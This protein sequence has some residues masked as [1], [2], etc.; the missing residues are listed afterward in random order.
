MNISSVVCISWYQNLHID[1]GVIY[2]RTVVVRYSLLAKTLEGNLPKLS[3]RPSLETATIFAKLLFQQN[4][5][6]SAPMVT[7]VL[8]VLSVVTPNNVHTNKRL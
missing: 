7:N 6:S 4:P 3:R 1:A 8:V 5:F 2:R